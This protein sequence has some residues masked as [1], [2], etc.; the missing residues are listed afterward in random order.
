MADMMVMP[1]L[2]ATPWHSSRISSP[3]RGVVSLKA[4]V[5]AI[6][7]RSEGQSN[8]RSSD[9]SCVGPPPPPPVPKPRAWRPWRS[10]CTPSGW[11]CCAGS[12]ASPTYSARSPP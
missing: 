4:R 9:Q 3:A 8:I 7:A 1:W 11:R 10:R 2:L 5:P 12:P 6:Q